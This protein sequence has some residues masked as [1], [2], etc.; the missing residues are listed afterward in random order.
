MTILSFIRF[1]F[2]LVIELSNSHQGSSLE[3]GM[4]ITSAELYLCMLIIVLSTSYI[5]GLTCSMTAKM[6]KLKTIVEFRHLFILFFIL[7]HTTNYV[8]PI[9]RD[10]FNFTEISINIVLIIKNTKH[11][12]LGYFH[13]AQ[14]FI[15]KWYLLD[16]YFRECT[17]FNEN[18]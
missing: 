8:F 1:F 17:R 18:H 9:V 4:N 11:I 2:F 14:N 6:L 5:I 16:Q 3:Q 13:G 10:L 12:R 15:H 7:Y